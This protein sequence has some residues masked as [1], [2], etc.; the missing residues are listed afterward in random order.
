MGHGS[1]QPDRGEEPDGNRDA[2][3]HPAL[4]AEAPVGRGGD[5]G[6]ED[7]E[8][9]DDEIVAVGGGGDTGDVVATDEEGEGD[10]HEDEEGGD[11]EEVGEDAE[12]CKE[13]DDG[14]GS[15]HGDCGVDGGAGFGVDLGEPWGH[16]VGS[17]NVGQVTGLAYC[18]HEED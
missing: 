12:V 6:S 4:R 9:E 10:E 5:G 11:G 16:H 15:H 18:A 13:T 2:V 8:E 3:P 7:E 17:G 1:P 14:G